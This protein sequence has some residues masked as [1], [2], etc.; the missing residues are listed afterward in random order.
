MQVAINAADYL[1]PILPPIKRFKY[2]DLSALAESA[3]TLVILPEFDGL[4]QAIAQATQEESQER[5]PLTISLLELLSGGTLPQSHKIFRRLLPHLYRPP[6]SS[7]Y[8]SPD[9]L[10]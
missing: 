9:M 6:Y 7:L 10:N 8:T 2:S 1:R 5:Q 3:P 4:D